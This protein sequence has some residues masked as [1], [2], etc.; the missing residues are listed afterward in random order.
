[1]EAPFVV[2]EAELRIVFVRPAHPLPLSPAFHEC[3]LRHLDFHQHGQAFVAAQ[4]IRHAA[5]N[6]MQLHDAHASNSQRSHN[7]VVVRVLLRR[8]SESHGHQ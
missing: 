7:L 2:G 6:P 1:M 3:R 8:T 5:A 4:Q